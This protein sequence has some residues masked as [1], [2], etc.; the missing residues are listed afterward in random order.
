LYGHLAQARIKSAAGDFD[1]ALAEAK[2][3]EAATPVDAQ[4]QVIHVLV[5][6]LEQ[7]QDINK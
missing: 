2:A 5:T 3:A 7:K 6:R 1:G 4:K